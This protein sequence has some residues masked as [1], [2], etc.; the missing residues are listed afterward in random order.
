MVEKQWRVLICDDD[1]YDVAAQLPVPQALEIQVMDRADD[2]VEQVLTWQPHAVLM[3]F[4]MRSPLKGD[5]A[6]RLLRASYG[7]T[8][9]IVGISSASSLN[10]RLQQAGA[11]FVVPKPQVSSLLQEL[12]MIIPASL[13][14]VPPLP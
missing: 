4:H 14:P 1:L 6:V 5:E 8:L 13:E 12:V 9:L 2:C 11:N 3:D 10:H 7:Q